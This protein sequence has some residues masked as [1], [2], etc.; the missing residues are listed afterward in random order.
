[1]TVLRKLCGELQEYGAFSPCRILHPS[2]VQHG[3]EVLVTGYV[4]M[5]RHAFQRHLRFLD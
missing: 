2:R 3:C 4:E 5:A 1:M